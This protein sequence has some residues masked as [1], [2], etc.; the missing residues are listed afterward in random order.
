M[1]GV[2]DIRS[3]AFDGVS[4]EVAYKLISRSESNPFAVTVSVEPRRGR[5]DGVTGLASTNY[6][7]TFKLFTDAVIVPDTLYWAANI[8]A[9]TQSSRDPLFDRPDCTQL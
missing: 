7:A 6:G 2:P 1:T 3:S 9:T 5:I 4:F 8:Q